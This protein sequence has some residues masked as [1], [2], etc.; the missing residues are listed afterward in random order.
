MRGLFIISFVESGPKQTNLGETREEFGGKGVHL[1][2]EDGR[3]I[4]GIGRRMLQMGARSESERGKCVP[5][6]AS[7]GVA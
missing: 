6:A 4:S 7:P 1:S 3:R 5:Q 2:H